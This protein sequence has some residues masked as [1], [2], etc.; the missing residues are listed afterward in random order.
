MKKAV[1]IDIGGT[2]TRVAAVSEQ[3]NVLHR[4]EF[5]TPYCR[6]PKDTVIEIFT[7]IYKSNLLKKIKSVGVGVPAIIHPGTGFV[8][9]SPNLGWKN[10]QI[11]KSVPAELG[12]RKI[13]FENDAC[14]A[15]WGVYE[16]LEKKVNSLCVITLGTGVGGG[17][18]T[19][20]RLY[21]GP[22]VSAFEIGHT[23]VDP[24]GRRCGCGARGCLET[25]CGARHM[26]R[27]AS[28]YWKKTRF[29][30][31][32]L[33]PLE[34][35][36]EAAGGASWAEKIWE[37]YG[38]YLGIAVANFINTLAVERVVFTGGIASAFPLFKHGLMKI[39][40]ERALPPYGRVKMTSVKRNRYMGAIGAARLAQKNGDGSGFI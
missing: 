2:N 32:N 28:E 16:S 18:I 10:F 40:R 34:I 39:V 25:F 31:K 14:C 26:N 36:S 3:G 35:A 9:F 4:A 6:R 15:A 27:W 37:K 11:K 13:V 1:G 24:A 33:T 5:K 22:G 8:Y 12:I 7:R 21:S 23:V 20:G 38:E 30:G 17:F 19:G 29:A